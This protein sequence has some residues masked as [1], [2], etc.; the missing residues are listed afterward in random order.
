MELLGA[1]RVITRFS[2]VLPRSTL[3]QVSLPG[4]FHGVTSMR[5]AWG[6]GRCW[7]AVSYG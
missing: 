3:R 5:V 6:S 2:P 4:R 7:E 1:N